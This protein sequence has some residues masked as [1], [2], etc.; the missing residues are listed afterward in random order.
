HWKPSRSPSRVNQVENYL[1]SDIYP[2]MGG[3]PV[4]DI[5][6]AVLR[7]MLRKIQAR[8]AP[9]VA[10]VVLQICNQVLRYA[11]AH[12]WAERNPV[13]ELRTGDLLSLPTAKNHA[14]VSEADLPALLHAIDSYGGEEQ[15]RL[16]LKLMSYC[17][18][19]TGELVDA[20]WSEFDLDHAR[21]TIPAERMKMRTPHIVPLSRQAADVVRRLKEISVGGEFVFPG[22]HSHKR[23]M[24]RATMLMALQALGYRGRMTVHGFRGVASTILHEQGW[25]HEHI[26]LQL[27]HQS[28][29]KVS[30]AYNHAQYLTQRA[31]MMQAWADYLD[32]QRA[33]YVRPV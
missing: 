20:P 7:E 32:A 18:V 31:E 24:S 13:A 10:K 11:M 25:S 4:T 21:W 28:R 3:R 27:A 2:I 19:R 23:P 5:R 1:A 8:G 29:G 9:S 14:R 12:D 17:F 15:T 6:P 33:R 26:E 22:Y 16:A 30:G